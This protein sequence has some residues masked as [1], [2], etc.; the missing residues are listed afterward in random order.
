[1]VLSLYQSP[2]YDLHFGD[3]ELA[4]ILSDAQDIRN[5]GGLA[6][7]MPFTVGAY[8]VFAASLAGLPL[9]TGFYSKD[10]ILMATGGR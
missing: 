2:L 6:R 3:A 10:G 8:L 7:K 4:G 1:M 9:F 5:M